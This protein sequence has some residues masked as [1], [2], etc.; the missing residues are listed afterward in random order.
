M[1][2]VT[3]AC[4]IG[5]VFGNTFKTVYPAVKNYDTYFFTNNKAIESELENKG[6]KYIFVDFPL[7]NDIAVSSLQSKYI[8]FLQFL[9]QEDFS[10]F[11]KYDKIIYIDHKL[12]LK[13]K[14]IKHLLEKSDDCDI[15]IRT[16][17]VDRKNIWEEVRD[18]MHQERYLKFMF[19]TADWIVEKIK[20]GYSEKPI[21]VW[22]SLMLYKHLN[23]RTINFTDMV[24]NDLIKIGTPECQIVWSMLGQK[25]MDII[26]IIKWNDLDIKW[27]NPDENI[28][29]KTLKNIILIFIP[30]GIVKFIEKRK[31]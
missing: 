16:N 18:A 5:C 1:E 14:H 6:W 7:S 26:K 20:E 17:Y 28:F 25:N 2:K 10:F 11:K 8:K 31:T 4:V 13:D 27:L 29:L 15:L 9:K 22:T 23:E 30:Y 12:E 21:V 3:K 19:Q 24:Y